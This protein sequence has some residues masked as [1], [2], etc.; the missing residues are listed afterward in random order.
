MPVCWHL[1]LCRSEN[2]LPRS[3]ATEWTPRACE[4]GQRLKWSFTIPSQRY[5]KEQWPDVR[6]PSKPAC[7]CSL[8]FLTFDN[9]SV[10]EDER[11]LRAR[12]RNPSH[13]CSIWRHALVP[14]RRARHIL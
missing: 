10:E 9:A 2:C 5:V 3:R 13:P 4:Q 12:I 8:L 11:L 1:L 6:R 7:A 14:S